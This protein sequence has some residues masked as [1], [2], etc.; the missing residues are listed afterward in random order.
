M[1]DKDCGIG[2]K[3]LDQV[4]GVPAEYGRLISPVSRDG[5]R[6]VTTHEGRNG[7]VS[8]V[9]ELREKIAIGVGIIGEAVEAEDERPAPR[10]DIAE[11]HRICCY[12]PSFEVLHDG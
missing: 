2:P 11:V 1:A 3:S 9:G 4:Q 6:S 10:L 7:S 12:G 8:G 5:C